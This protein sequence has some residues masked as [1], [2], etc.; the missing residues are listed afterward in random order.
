MKLKTYII[1]D[2]PTYD[3]LF[4]NATLPV[5]TWTSVCHQKPFIAIHH[6]TRRWVSRYNS[7][8]NKRPFQVIYHG[9]WTKLGASATLDGAERIARVMAV[10]MK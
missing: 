4:V 9:M 2:S 5:V 8:E 1:N 10:A 7:V 6:N 3:H